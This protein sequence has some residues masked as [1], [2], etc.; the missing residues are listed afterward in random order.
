[1]TSPFLSFQ[2]TYEELKQ[3]WRISVI[4][5]PISGFQPTYEELKHWGV[6]EGLHRTKVFSLPMRN[7]N[8]LQERINEL[9][10]VSFQPTY[11]ELKPARRAGRG[12]ERE[13]FSAY[14]WGIET[15]IPTVLGIKRLRFQPTYE[16]LKLLK[17]FRQNGM[18]SRVF[19][20]PMRNWNS[21]TKSNKFTTA[22]S[23][24]AYLWGIETL[25]R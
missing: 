2:P 13:Q 23:F 21:R 3:D 10:K 9:Q 17:V 8:E 15:Y 5:E 24:S 7:W 22:S 20:L 12:S 16:E 19:S 14:L 25:F 1:M 6:S 11:E 4:L 18:E